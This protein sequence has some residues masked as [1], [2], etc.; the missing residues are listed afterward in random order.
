MNFYVT[1]SMSTEDTCMMSSPDVKITDEKKE[2]DTLKDAV[3]ICEN[4]SRVL[5]ELSI[6]DNKEVDKTIDGLWSIINIIE[7]CSKG[8]NEDDEKA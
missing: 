8:E 1:S 6:F 5:Y 7:E 2:L 3:H 4:F